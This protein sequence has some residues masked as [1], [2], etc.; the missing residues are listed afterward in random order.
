MKTVFEREI[1]DEVSGCYGQPIDEPSKAGKSY[2][3]HFHFHGWISLCIMFFAVLGE[4]LQGKG[5]ALGDAL[6]P[7]GERASGMLCPLG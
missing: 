4:F 2:H 6:L 1:C 5:H 7:L 3:P